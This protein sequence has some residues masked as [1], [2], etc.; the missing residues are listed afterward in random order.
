MRDLPFAKGQA[1]GND[2]LVVDAAHLDSAP[3]APLARALCDRNRGAGSDGLCVIDV[4][5]NPFHLQIFNPD[6][7]TAEKSGNGLR[8]V[9]AYLHTR[10]LVDVG[11]EFAVRLPTDTVRLRVLGKGDAGELDIIADMGR[12]DFSGSSIG[13]TARGEVL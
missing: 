3:T 12:A 11:Q 10:G 6:G 9:A 5:A 13:Y 4:K 2:Y 7:S 8:I 1:L